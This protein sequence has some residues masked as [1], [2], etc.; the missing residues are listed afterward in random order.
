MRKLFTSGIKKEIEQAD[1]YEV[2]S[3]YESQ[4]LG[5]QLER[6]WDNQRLK[7]KPIIIFASL[8]LLWKTIHANRCFSNHPNNDHVF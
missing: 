3:S 4:K 2:L 7:S 5:N 1:I 6:K 8:E